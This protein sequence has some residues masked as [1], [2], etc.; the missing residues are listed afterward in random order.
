MSLSLHA[1]PPAEPISFEGLRIR[2]QDLGS[3]QTSRPFQVRCWRVDE[4]DDCPSQDA[5]SASKGAT[6]TY[7]SP[8][9]PHT[10]VSTSMFTPKRAGVLQGLLPTA[11]V[12][13]QTSLTPRPSP[14]P[15]QPI[16]SSILSSIMSSAP[17]SPTSA[18]SIPFSRAGPTTLPPQLPVPSAVLTVTTQTSIPE[19]QYSS[20][21]R[22]DPP[23]ANPL[24]LVL[25][26]ASFPFLASVTIFKV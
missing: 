17:S 15:S 20:L 24:A 6:A 12:H 9:P 18:L 25:D 23:P 10:H 2:E 8:R 26:Q 21:L 3:V 4:P 19:P 1:S 11:P 7:I 16:N 5:S 13:A 22:P 14:S